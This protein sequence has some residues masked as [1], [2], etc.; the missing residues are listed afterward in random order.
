[1]ECARPRAQQR[2]NSA[3]AGQFQTLT[4]AEVAATGDGRAP[5]PEHCRW[6]SQDAR[7]WSNLSLNCN[8]PVV[9]AAK[10]FC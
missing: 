4:H 9:G 7:A 5:A 10:R 3:A 1:M 6:L 2:S 8:L